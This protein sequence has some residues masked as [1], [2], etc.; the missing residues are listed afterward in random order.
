M[1]GSHITSG[2]LPA[3]LLVQLPANVPGQEA[4]DGPDTWASATFVRDLAAVKGFWLHSGPDLAVAAIWGMNQLNQ[5]MNEIYLSV[6]KIN[7]A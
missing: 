1:L 3:L 2:I 7:K 5:Q 4:E 6:F